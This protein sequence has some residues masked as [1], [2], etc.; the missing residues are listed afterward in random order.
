GP[1]PELRAAAAY[2]I[3]MRVPLAAETPALLNAVNDAVPAVRE[4]VRRALR[5]SSDPKAQ[6]ALERIS[7]KGE[8]EL[9][10]TPLSM[11]TLGVPAYGG[12]AYAF[13][14]SAPGEGRAEFVTADPVSKVVAFYKS[15]AVKPPLSLDAFSS[16]YAARAGGS[17]FSSNRDGSST[18]PGA[19][20]MAQAMAMAQQ[21][22]QE[23][24]GK[25]PEE[26]QRALAQGA[27]AQQ[28]PSAAERY[29]NDELYGAPQVIV[30]Q[31]SKFMGATR[32]SRYLV[33]F[34][35]KVFGTTGIAV[36][37]VIAP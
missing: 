9:A 32:P 20:Q 22:A 7:S 14:A 26:M 17:L 3:G 16:A 18:M 31:E 37:Y 25:S 12:A 6:A 29:G 13:F 27:A 33:V 8:G 24:E 15:K 11:S 1:E 28:A 10:E 21:M 34:E 2:A 30:L 35:D 5:A 4:S 23:L 19:D 36:H